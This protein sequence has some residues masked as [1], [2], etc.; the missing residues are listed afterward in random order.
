MKG[1]YQVIT[2][3]GVFL[4]TVTVKGAFAKAKSKKAI[5]IESDVVNAFT[6]DSLPASTVS[7]VLPITL[8]NNDGDGVINGYITITSEDACSFTALE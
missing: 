4:D 2:L 5:L 3:N 7:A 1:G 8:I 6:F